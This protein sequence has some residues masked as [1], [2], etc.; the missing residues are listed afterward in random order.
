MSSN[1]ITVYGIV[2]ASGAHLAK[3][4]DGWKSRTMTVAQKHVASLNFERVFSQMKR[5]ATEPPIVYF[6]SYGD[7]WSFPGLLLDVAFGPKAKRFKE[8]QF[9]TWAICLSS[10]VIRNE[11]PRLAS[12][13]RK[14]K[15]PSEK[16]IRWFC[17][18][19]AE[20]AE[21]M[22]AFGAGYV[23]VHVE[24]IGM[25]VEDAEIADSL[26]DIA[27]WLKVPTTRRRK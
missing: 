15:N 19:L 2:G 22:A 25:S 14:L 16:E 8:A 10:R 23:F 13:A 5:H 17:T 26:H 27:P 9:E 21:T 12:I 4:F 1:V 11:A 24:P 7:A 6:R 3:A 18:A 20:C